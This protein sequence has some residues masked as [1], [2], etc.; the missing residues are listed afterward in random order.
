MTAIYDPQ[1]PYPE[2]RRI[3]RG[4]R[5]DEERALRDLLRAMTGATLDIARERRAEEQQQRRAG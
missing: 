2:E 1:P 5:A 4:P 3:E